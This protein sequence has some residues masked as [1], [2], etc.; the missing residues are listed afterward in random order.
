MYSQIDGVKARI[1][2]PSI[3]YMKSSGLINV[4]ALLLDKVVQYPKPVPIIHWT[5][6]NISQAR[7]HIWLEKKLQIATNIMDPS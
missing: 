3:K 6:I 1:K 7:G 2:K 5:E 4:G